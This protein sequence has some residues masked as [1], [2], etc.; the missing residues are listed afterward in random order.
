VLAA[1][2]KSYT[3]MEL[4][5]SKPY[6]S[7]TLA[8]GLYESGFLAPLTIL[9]GINEFLATEAGTILVAWIIFAIISYLVMRRLMPKRANEKLY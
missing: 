4:V 3:F 7:L 6:G 1:Y 9:G 5:G 8:L 2:A